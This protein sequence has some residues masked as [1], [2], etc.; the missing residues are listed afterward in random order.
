MRGYRSAAQIISEVPI[1]DGT[2]AREIHGFRSRDGNLLESRLRLIPLIPDEWRGAA[3]PDALAAMPVALAPMGT[4]AAP[5][6]LIVSAEGVYLLAA[7]DRGAGGA[8]PGLEELQLWDGTTATSLTL[9]EPLLSSPSIVVVSPV[10]AYISFGERYRPV[11][12]DLDERRLR[13]F[14]FEARP[15][16]PLVRGPSRVGSSPNGAGFTV[17]GRV[18]TTDGSWT[19]AGGATVGGIDDGEWRYAVVFENRDGAYSPTSPLSAA[20]TIRRT[21]ADPAG[22]TEVEDLPRRFALR[23]I[24]KGPPETVARILLRTL[25]LRRIPP[26][27]S[28]APQF[29]TRLS[30]R[31]ATEWVDDAPD[32]ELGAVW[33]ERAAAPRWSVAT[34]SQ[35]SL[36]VAMGSTLYWSEQTSLLGPT[37]ESFLAGAYLPIHPQSGPIVALAEARVG[38]GGASA[39]PALLVLKGAVACYVVGEYPSFQT[40]VLHPSAGAA[41]PQVVQGTGDGGVVWFGAGTFWRLSPEGAVEDIGGTIRKLLARVN[42]GRAGWGRSW[43]DLEAREVVFCLPVD[44]DRWPTMQF[45]L[46]VADGGW[47][48]RQDVEVHAACALTSDRVVVLSGRYRD[49]DGNNVDNVFVYGR[50][51]PTFYD[52]EQPKARYVTGWQSPVQGVGMHQPHGTRTVFLITEERGYTAAADL[53]LTAYQDWNLDVGTISPQQVFGANPN[54]DTEEKPISFWGGSGVAPADDQAVWGEAWWREA[55]SV[56]QR[57]ATD[58]ASAA[59]SA[60]SLDDATGMLALLLVDVVTVEQADGVGGRTPDVVASY[61]A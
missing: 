18:G 13:Y 41:G 42:Q 5:E 34:F 53:T 20:A 48:T 37:P 43:V 46:D 28:G 15:A 7:W 30:N 6:L 2:T 45:I 16:A 44:D 22:G 17:R 52:Y 23:S 1:S 11:V 57:V 51:I 54:A 61:K 39:R 21:L 60:M 32:G 9:P 25:N 55:R 38:G 36:W 3:P 19:E 12:V 35:G 49:S 29:L 58:T 40:G 56:D 26:G 33:E 27:M 8:N 59:V 4:A 10:R 50:S 14:G 24:P 47:R 31:Q